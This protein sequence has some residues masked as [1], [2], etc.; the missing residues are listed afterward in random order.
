MINKRDNFFYDVNASGIID[1]FRRGPKIGD[2]LKFIYKNSNGLALYKAQDSKSFFVKETDVKTGVTAISS[3]RL[4]KHAGI[5]TPPV[6]FIAKKDKDIIQTLQQNVEGINGL[7]TIL[8]DDDVEYKKIQTQAFGKYK[9]QLFYDERLINALLKFMTPECLTQFQNMYL[10][11]ELRTDGDKHLK[12]YFFYKQKESGLYEGI[13]AVDLD[14]MQIYNYCGAKQ[15]DFTNFLVYPYQT[16]LPQQLCDSVSYKQRMIDMRQLVQDDVLSTS[17]IETIKNT[18]EFDYPKETSKV[19]K[20]AKLGYAERKEIVKPV[21]R[22]WEYNRET[23]GKDL[24]L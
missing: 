23:I 4:Y 6:E 20:E 8:A 17:N 1:K 2:A 5:L 12:N 3:S 13:I 9:W 11:D 24:G 22:L 10:V 18:L 14:L 15:A 21:E 16:A 19:C 7:E